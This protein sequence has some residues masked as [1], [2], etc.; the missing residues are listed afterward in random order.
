MRKVIE[1]LL[2]LLAFLLTTKRPVTAEEIRHQVA[3]YDSPTDAAFHR[4][5]ERDKDLLRRIGIPL[6]LSEGNGWG[7]EAGY[8]IDPDAYRIPDPGLTD[9]ERAALALAS[10]VVRLGGGPAAPEA[11]LK[12]GGV[13]PGGGE[14][15]LGADLGLAAGRLGD[16]FAA[17]TE[18]RIVTFQYNDKPRQVEP[19]GLAHRR[20]HWYLVGGVADGTRVFRVDR[21]GVLEEVSDAE[22]FQ[23]PA[24]FDLRAEIDA[25]PWE[26]GSDETIVAR[27]RFDPEL[28]WWAARTLRVE[29]DTG[30]LAV[31]LPVA[32]VDAFIGWILSFDDAAVVEGPAELRRQV[33]E[34]VEAALR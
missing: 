34:R 2:N 29:H 9:E 16:L 33:V 4:M 19:Y 12:L 15:P 21:M 18:R 3:G 26:A 17:V 24:D 28:A 31:D 10:R 11:L 22:A 5:F 23:R 1:R 25:H 14:E 32:N 7:I 20:G 6:E 8:V 27:V 30:A 13:G